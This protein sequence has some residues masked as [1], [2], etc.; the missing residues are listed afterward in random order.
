MV[1]EGNHQL[2]GVLVTC[3]NISEAEKIA[4]SLIEKKLAACVNYIP[5]LSSIYRWKGKIEKT[6]EVLLII[7]TQEKSLGELIKVVK[8]LHSYEVPEVISFRITGGNPEY[9]KW[10]IQETQ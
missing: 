10:V 8:K 2:I 3:Q 5:G 7:K 6:K 4:F 1:K 9:L